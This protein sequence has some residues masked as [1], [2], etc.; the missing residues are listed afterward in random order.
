MY[1]V[2]A[3]KTDMMIISAVFPVQSIIIPKIELK[4]SAL[5]GV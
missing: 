5:A 1:K 4:I 3:P 2:R